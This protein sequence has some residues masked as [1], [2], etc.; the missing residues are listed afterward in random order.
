MKQITTSKGKFLF[1]QVPEGV[2]EIQLETRGNRFA[3][4]TEKWDWTWLPKGNWQFINT[5]KD[6]TEEQAKEFV[7][8]YRDTKMFHNY[9]FN[10]SN[11]H[12][13]AFN[14]ALQAFQ[15]LL[16][17]NEI[18]ENSVVLKLIKS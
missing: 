3:F 14:S 9:L 13:V 10:G 1:V 2:S 16:Q 6:I 11:H 17:A 15:S 7:D 8:A 12:L 5:C 18:P 4:Y